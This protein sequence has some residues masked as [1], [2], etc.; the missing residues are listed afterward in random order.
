MALSGFGLFVDFLLNVSFS[1]L[2]GALDI[3]C[4]SVNEARMFKRMLFYFWDS[5]QYESLHADEPL[6]CPLYCR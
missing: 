1:F 2:G 3:T 6:G 4:S 5:V